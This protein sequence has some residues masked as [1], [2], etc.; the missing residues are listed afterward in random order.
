MEN[1]DLVKAVNKIVCDNNAEGYNLK[2]NDI[3]FLVTEI[4]EL[5]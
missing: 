5:P 4:C 2:F 1:P 3:N